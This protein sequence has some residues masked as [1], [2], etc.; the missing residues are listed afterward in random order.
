[1]RQRRD[2]LFAQGVY[3]DAMHAGASDYA[4]EHG[5]RLRVMT[6]VSGPVWRYWR[7]DGILCSLGAPDDDLTKFIRA[8]PGPKVEMS[9]YPKGPGFGQVGEDCE[10]IGRMAAD[11]FCGLGYRHFLYVASGKASHEWRPGEAFRL[12]VRPQAQ[13]FRAWYL[14]EVSA[15]WNVA[16]AWVERR[17]RRLPRPVAIY[18][19]GDA[20][21]DWLSLACQDIGL[22]VPGQAAILGTGNISFVCDQALIPLSSLD[23]NHRL[24]GYKAAEMLDQMLDGSLPDRQ[25][26]LIPPARVVERRST[27]QASS[28]DPRVAAALAFIGQRLATP[29]S[30]EE[31]ALAA[32]VSAPTLNRLFRQ[33]LSCTVGAR[34][35]RTR[36]DLAKRL[37]QETDT[38]ASEVAR[39]VGFSSPYY[40]YRQFRKHTGGGTKEFRS[41]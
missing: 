12:A 23:T 2:I 14:S 8:F 1:M 9:F 31:I 25:L 33:H 7:G 3:S 22:A 15:D 19:S 13:S 26:W 20:L 41:P 24:W 28:V 5:W 18:C 17:L 34:L 29:I 40:F 32:G 27:G 10:A 38:P 37:L 21:A 4:R 30:V 6:P 35:A 36:I 16:A 11:Y 39:Q